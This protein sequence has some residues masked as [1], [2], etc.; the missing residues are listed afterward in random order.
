MAIAS[1]SKQLGL[2]PPGEILQAG[3]S[4][5]DLDIIKVVS[6]SLAERLRN[7]TNTVE[8]IDTL[9]KEGLDL[10][11]A[12][13]RANVHAH[14]LCRKAWLLFQDGH[15]EAG[16]DEYDEA[17][18][19]KELPSAW[20][21]KGTLLLQLDRPDEAFE[22]F[23][24]AHSLR[25]DWGTSK[26]N[27]LT[28]LF[29]GWSTAAL[30]R[31]LFGIVQEDAQEAKKGV[32]EYIDLPDRAKGDDLASAVLNLA[33]EK[34]VSENLQAALEELELMVRLVS[35][36]DPFEGWR[37]LT[38]EISKVWPEGVSAVDAIREQRE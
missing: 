34:P 37:A 3:L 32:D 17:L 28:N 21:L 1:L 15:E 7:N 12:P 20:A 8:Q 30:L 23:R 6:G 18:R 33:V 11:P 27:H 4:P 5:E 22:A 26:L 36:K 16:L 9:I 14:L 25:D 19:V 13:E 10:L 24:K 31:A 38:K 29:G 2:K 35:I